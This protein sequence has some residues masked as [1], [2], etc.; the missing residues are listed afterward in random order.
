MNPQC[1]SQEGEG[2][3]DSRHQGIEFKHIPLAAFWAF[4]INNGLDSISFH[5]GIVVR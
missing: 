5:N 4:T 3:Q 1:V 2:N